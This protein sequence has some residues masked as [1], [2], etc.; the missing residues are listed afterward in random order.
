[1]TLNCIKN[2]ITTTANSIK[3]KERHNYNNMNLKNLNGNGRCETNFYH[4]KALILL[5]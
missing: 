5:K 2:R 3:K 1:M 4:I